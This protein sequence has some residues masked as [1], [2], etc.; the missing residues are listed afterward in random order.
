MRR[1]GALRRDV[2]L[3]SGIG[4]FETCLSVRYMSAI[5]E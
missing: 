5:G 4:T 1:M 2:V 3:M